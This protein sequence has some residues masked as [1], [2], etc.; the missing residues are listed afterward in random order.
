[1]PADDTADHAHADVANWFTHHAPTF[2]QA[3]VYEELRGAA[4]RYAHTIAELVPAG[5]DRDR[6]FAAARESVMWANAAIACHE[7][8]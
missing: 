8:T 5:P 2:D 6:A 3:R 1:M 4:G 7:G